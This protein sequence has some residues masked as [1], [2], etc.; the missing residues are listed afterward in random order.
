MTEEN[1]KFAANNAKL[2]GEVNRLEGEVDKMAQVWQNMWYSRYYYNW[3][4]Y[5]TVILVSHL[6]KLPSFD[7]AFSVAFDVFRLD[8]VQRY[9]RNAARFILQ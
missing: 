2:E 1:N 7:D 6:Y 8:I 9:Y 4:L 3:Y 5:L